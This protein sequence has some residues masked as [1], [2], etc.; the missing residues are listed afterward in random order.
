VFNANNLDSTKNEDFAFI[1]NG[2]LIING[3]GTLQVVDI[4][5]RVILNANLSTLTSHLPTS[6]L[7]PGV[8]MSRLV[9]GENVKTQ[10]IIIK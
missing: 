3:T 5:G 2:E 8:Y 4:L 7:T 1:S 10:K 6:Y 9:N